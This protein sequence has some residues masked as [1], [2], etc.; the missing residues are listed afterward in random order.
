MTPD[1]LPPLREVIERHGLA[2]KKSLGQN[3]L[4][5]LNLTGKVA[6]AA[7]DLT[8]ATVIEVGPGPGGLTRALLMHGAARVIAVER[9]ERCLPALAE[10]SAAYPGRLD[11]ISGDALAT[12]FAT[13]TAGEDVRIAANL[14][15]N[16]GTELLLRWVATASWPPFWQ[17]MTLMFQREVAERIVAGPDD[18]AFGRLGVLCGWRTEAKIAFDIAPQAFWPPPKVKSSVTHESRVS[19]SRSGARL[20]G[21]RLSSA[22]FDYTFAFARAALLDGSKNGLWRPVEQIVVDPVTDEQA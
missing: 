8:G 21:T 7:G 13:L 15:Y 18:D 5:D 1:G 2:A 10:I 17:S 3:F 11:V 22:D 16:I 9:D 12:D 20:V 6:R 4:L 19:T 14:P